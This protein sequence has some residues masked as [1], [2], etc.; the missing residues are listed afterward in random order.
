M[1]APPSLKPATIA[2]DARYLRE[3]EED[4]DKRRRA[5]F[6]Q[7][8]DAQVEKMSKTNTQAMIELAARC[9]GEAPEAAQRFAKREKLAT[10]PHRI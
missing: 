2:A 5:Y 6:L 7:F 10:M 3:T 9:R 1:F 4:K 8:S